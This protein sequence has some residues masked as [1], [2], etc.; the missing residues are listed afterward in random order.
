MIP[1]N[2]SCFNTVDPIYMV[3]GMTHTIVGGTQLVMR[4]CWHCLIGQ[5]LSI[6]INPSN[7][8]FSEFELISVQTTQFVLPSDPSLD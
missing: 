5:L 8:S 1:A 3:A 4:R 6:P 2:D 7:L